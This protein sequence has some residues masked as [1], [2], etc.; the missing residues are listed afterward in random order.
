M[1]AD[2]LPGTPFRTSRPQLIASDLE[3][4]S[5]FAIA[6]DGTFYAIV[7]EMPGPLPARGITV[8]TAW[9]DEIRKV[10]ARR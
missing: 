2:V 1:G 5:A 4:V 8:V 10:H 7:N 6:R 9:F 3:G